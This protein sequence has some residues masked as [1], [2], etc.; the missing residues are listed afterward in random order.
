MAGWL[1]GRHPLLVVRLIVPS[2]GGVA[3]ATLQLRRRL[4]SG[5]AVRHA[6][7]LHLLIRLGRR[8]EVN[9]SEVEV[10]FG[11]RT[12]PTPCAATLK[13]QFHCLLSTFMQCI[14]FLKR[15][16]IPTISQPE[17][18]PR[19]STLRKLCAKQHVW[20]SPLFALLCKG[21][22]VRGVESTNGCLCDITKRCP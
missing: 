17:E 1:A 19:V 4:F 7:G 20:I 8:L 10:C 5:S 3:M 9:K 14:F 16:Q 13:G 2:P 11:G 6:S 22:V 12:P 15:S 18:L 21:R